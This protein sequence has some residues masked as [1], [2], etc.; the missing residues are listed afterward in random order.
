MD[1]IEVITTCQNRPIAKFMSKLIYGFVSNKKLKG[2]ANKLP[3]MICQVLMTRRSIFISYFVKHTLPIPIDNMP[4]ARIMMPDTVACVSFKYGY[5]AINKP[6]AAIHIP[7]HS[8][9]VTFLLKNIEDNKATTNGFTVIN[10]LNKLDDTNFSDKKQQPTYKVVFNIPSTTNCFHSTPLGHLLDLIKYVKINMIR[11]ALIN[12]VVANIKG[13]EDK[14][15]IFV[16][17]APDAH[18]ILNNIP[19]KISI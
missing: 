9:F 16:A 15:P 10:K 14:R 11:P 5:T 17:I 18:K 8:C 12:L 1:T 7:A 6:N 19:I 3:K 2:T 13:D 4:I